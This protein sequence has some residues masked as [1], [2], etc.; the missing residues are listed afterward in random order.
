M[1]AITSETQ[2]QTFQE[3]WGMGDKISK[4]ALPPVFG[5]LSESHE[6]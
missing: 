2:E 3:F 6:S 4:T 5:E 1:G